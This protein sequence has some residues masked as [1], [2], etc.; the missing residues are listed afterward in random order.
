MLAV[1][2]SMDNPDFKPIPKKA[3]RRKRYGSDSE[4]SSS[5][6]KKKKAA[7]ARK[8]MD[9]HLKHTKPMRANSNSDESWLQDQ[10]MISERLEDE[11]RVAGIDLNIM[12][13]SLEKGSCLH[14]QSSTFS[15]GFPRNNSTNP[16][17]SMSTTFK[18]K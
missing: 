3:T 10:S 14:Q 1:L 9:S 7:E 11:N 16:N 6:E 13:P 4:E 18:S 8:K 12:A 5:A 2:S 15:G 17:S